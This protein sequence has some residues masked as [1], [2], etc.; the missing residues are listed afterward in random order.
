MF[1]SKTALVLRATGS[2]G[3]G[4]VR[5]LVESGWKV[6]ALV[7]DPSEARAVA[8][9]QSDNVTLYKGALG[10]HASIEAAIAGTNAVFLTQ[11]P[12]WVDD[13][14][15]QDATAV[16][17]L[18]KAAGVKYLVYSSVLTL[19]DPDI[20]DHIISPIMAPALLGKLAVEALVRSSGM[21][22]TILRPGWFM[23][24]LLP[25]MADMM[26]PG[27]SEGSFVSSYT[28]DTI[29]TAV[30]PDDVGAFTVAAFNDPKKFSGKAVSIVG[31]LITVTDLLAGI[32]KVTG[33]VLDIHYRTEEETQKEKNNPLVIG[34]KATIG[35]H[36]WANMDEIKGFGIALT[37]FNQF[38]E[39]NKEHV[40]PKY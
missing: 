6:H 24:N 40:V 17:T 2:Q 18:A 16:L 37:T 1:S 22:Y 33:R 30:D 25:P 27:I 4:V 11:M 9:Q 29:I 12:S 15:L 10:D 23:T 28:P 34:Q 26:F 39:K 36:K 21:R 31:Q 3:K 8:L 20:R 19:N 32:E 14:E 13:S 38:L 35:L 5:H 7:S